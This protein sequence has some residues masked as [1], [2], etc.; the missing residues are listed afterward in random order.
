M[1]DLDT[2]IN[3]FRI[4]HDNLVAQF[5]TVAADEAANEQAAGNIQT[6]ALTTTNEVLTDTGKNA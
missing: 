4:V 6:N 5:T 3:S 1:S 2:I